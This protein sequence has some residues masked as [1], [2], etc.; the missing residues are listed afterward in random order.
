MCLI[1]L[2][3][4]I[5]HL[6]SSG[7]WF[8]GIQERT[9]KTCC[10]RKIRPCAQM[11][12]TILDSI[13][14]TIEG[15]YLR[16]Q[17]ACESSFWKYVN[18]GKV[19]KFLLCWELMWGRWLQLVVAT[20]MQLC[21]NTKNVYFGKRGMFSWCSCRN[22]LCG[23]NNHSIGHLDTLKIFKGF[24]AYMWLEFYGTM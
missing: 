20:S 11:I 17:C 14:N 16:I 15:N 18:S 22:G 8:G 19:V 3:A 6:H 5:K 21:M 12:L 9:P 24:F 7:V 1:W 10:L 4:L 13:I 2:L 23:C